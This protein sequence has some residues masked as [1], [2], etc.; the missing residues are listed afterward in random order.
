MVV[1]EAEASVEGASEEVPQAFEWVVLGPAE[2]HLGELE[3]VE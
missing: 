2:L 1:F 3:P